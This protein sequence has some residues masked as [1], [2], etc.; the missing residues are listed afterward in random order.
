MNTLNNLTADQRAQLVAL[1]NSQVG[2]INECDINEYGY[3]RFVLMD[4]FRRLAESDLPAGTTGLDK[5]AVK[6]YSAELYQ[7]DGQISF[8]RA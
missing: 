6:A 8:E 2:D 7:L 5:E 4:A 3:K 1:A